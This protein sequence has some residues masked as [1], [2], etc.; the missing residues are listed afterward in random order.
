MRIHLK[1]MDEIIWKI[2]DEGYVILNEANPTQVD[3]ENQQPF[4]ISAIMSSI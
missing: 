1:A 2:I 3:N 4:L